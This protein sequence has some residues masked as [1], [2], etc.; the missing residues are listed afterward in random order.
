MTHQQQGATMAAPTI[1]CLV[2]AAMQ[3]I[4][5]WYDFGPAGIDSVQHEVSGEGRY[6]SLD[7]FGLHLT[8]FYGRTPKR[9]GC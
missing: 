7:W 4:E 9:E 3:A 5:P 8:V 6:F 1:R 2:H